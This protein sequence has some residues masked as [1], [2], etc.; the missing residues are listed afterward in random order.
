MTLD[1]RGNLK[2][3]KLSNNPY[4]VFEE[5]ISNAIDAYLIRTHE[6]TNAQNL[7]IGIVVKFEKGDLLS[8]RESLAISCEDNGCGLGDEQVSAFVTKDTSYK[9]DLPIAGIGKCKGTGRIQFFH[10]FSQISIDSV[11]Q[12]GEALRRRVL[13]YREPQKHVS[14]SDFIDMPVEDRKIGTVFKLESPRESIYVK[15]GDDEPLSKR[16]SAATLK[17]H[18]MVAFL[19]RLVGIADKL[20]DFQIKFTSQHWEQKEQVEIL[21]RSDLPAVT[22]VRPVQVEQQD[23][24]TAEGLGVTEIFRISHYKLD[25]K[26]Y[27]L[28]RNSIALCA[29]F[30]PVKDIT[31]RYLRTKTEQ[32]NAVSGFHHIVLVESPFLDRVVNEHRDDFDGIPSAAPTEDLYRTEKINYETLYKSIDSVIEEMVTP[33]DWSRDATLSE[34]TALFGITEAMLQDTSTRLVYGES[35]QA[36]AERVLKKYQERILDE[37]AEILHLKDEIVKMAPDSEDFRVKINELAWKYTSSL[38][39]FDMANLSQ[40]IVRRAA[41]V[42]IL[43][44][45]CKKQ[46]SVQLLP[47]GARRQD[48]KIIHSIFFPVKRDSVSAADHDIWLL[49]EEYHY[50]DY[51]ASELPLS[52]IKWDDH[53]KTFEPDIDDEFRKLLEK[54]AQDNGGKRPD[55]ALFNKEGA[56]I[57]I[58]FKAPGVPMDEHIGDLS[59]YSHL[60]A[61]KSRGKLRKF[62]GYLIGDTVNPLRLTGWTQFPTGNGLFRTDALQDPRTRQPL[63]ETY[64]EIL[65]YSDVIDRAKKRIAVYQ[66]KLRLKLTRE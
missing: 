3:T 31:Q 18:V 55:I 6:N 32:N 58:E 49:S 8:E 27:D 26:T 51:V 34:V 54:R 22:S 42:D 16:F 30:S 28:P 9:D 56:V 1:I 39:N 59:E 35:A 47:Q 57:I 65:H 48:E 43:A 23:P 64:Y 15:L 10:F 5:L 37:T 40:L 24:F 29:K 11:Y 60:L 13:H 17:M 63:G 25:A 50:F 2:N 14:T 12:N 36:V 33:A 21:G 20:G 38:K 44:L 52:Q 62:Y 66:N 53:E 4:V 19:Q 46:L 7:N 41:I 45:A 61:A